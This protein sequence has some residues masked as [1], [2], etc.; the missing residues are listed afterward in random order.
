MKKFAFLLLVLSLTRVAVAYAETNT[1]TNGTTPNQQNYFFG[2][3]A[4]AAANLNQVLALLVGPRGVP[5]PAGVA[6]KDGF[7]GLNGQN[8]KDGLP[9][10]PGAVGPQ[11]PAGL[12]GKDGVNGVNGANGAQ[13]PAGPAGAGGNAAYA[14]IPIDAT[15]TTDCPSGLGGLKYHPNTGNDTIVCNGGAGSGTGNLLN[16]QNGYASGA[17]NG[18]SCQGTQHIG[19]AFS[20]HFNGNDFVFG[21][22]ILTSVSDSVTAQNSTGCIGKT[23]NFYFKI[24]GSGTLNNTTDYSNGR[25]VKCSYPITATSF[26]ASA[27]LSTACVTSTDSTGSAYGSTTFPLGNISTADYINKIGF[28]IV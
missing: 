8:G 17:M 22:I 14:V 1:A 7:V 15:N 9:G 2:N 25:F 28:E 11:G 5:G 26:T 19:I 10:A 24:N 23:L 13:G 21:D 3:S 20:R 18:T 6:G 12:N 4:Q 16:I 27:S